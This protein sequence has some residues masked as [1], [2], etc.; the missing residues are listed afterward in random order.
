[1]TENEI[2]YEVRGAAFEV[3]NELGPGLLESIYE[4]AM[5]IV[6]REKGLQA[7]SQVSSAVNF[8][9]HDLGEGFRI[10]IFVENK[11]IVEIKSVEEMRKVYFKQLRTYLRLKDKKLG[12]L[13][14]FNSDPIFMKRMVNGL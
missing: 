6:L 7:F 9:G 5:L 8:R 2:S 14:N 3:Y 1:M 4:K 13:I 11:V 10:D 12:L